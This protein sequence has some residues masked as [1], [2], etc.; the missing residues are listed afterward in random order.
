MASGESFY[1]QTSEK[2]RVEYELA[3]LYH[4][5]IAFLIDVAIKMVVFVGVYVVL[6]FFAV[7][8]FVLARYVSLGNLPQLVMI[9]L[10]IACSLFFLLY[11]FLFEWLWKGYTPGKR[12][13]RIRAV[14]D[15]GM[16]IDFTSA[17]LRNIFRIVDVLPFGYL[18]GIVC[19]MFNSKRK[20]IGDFVA[21]TFVTRERSVEIIQIEGG[22]EN[23]FALVSNI[24][25]LF[26]PSFVEIVNSYL[27]AKNTMEKRAREK[28]ERELVTLIEA[29]TGVKLPPGVLPHVFIE[30][31]YRNIIS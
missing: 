31:L 8:S 22:V 10:I 25:K 30:S 12:I 23:Y 19:A 20:R 29:K 27:R 4:R 17:L 5:C 16:Y 14:R 11:G 9:V 15:D 26:S 13:M 21:G 18:V 3:S 24:N 6:I 2:V 28:V 1:Y 7:G